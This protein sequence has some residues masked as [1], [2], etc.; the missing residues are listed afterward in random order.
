MNMKGITAAIFL[1][2]L[3]NLE[4]N[5]AQQCT[6][7][8][9]TMPSTLNVWLYISDAVSFS[10]MLHCVEAKVEPG[11]DFWQDDALKWMNKKS[12][13]Q[14][15]CSH[16][17]IWAVKIKLVWSILDLD[18]LIMST[19][20]CWMFRGPFGCSAMSSAD[21]DFGHISVHNNGPICLKGMLCSRLTRAQHKREIN[22]VLPLWKK[23]K[24][25]CFWHLFAIRHLF[26]C[27][28]VTPGSEAIS[29]VLWM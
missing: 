20:S 4:V 2:F 26:F 14:T 22:T 1:L 9:F 24:I 7:V 25:I 6:A 29:S 16:I 8:P 3:N 11:S 10:M 19:Y 28:V 5:T 27:Q 12:Y 21:A 18:W 15:E 17:Q 13:C 23:R